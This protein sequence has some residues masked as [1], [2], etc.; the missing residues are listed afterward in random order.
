MSMKALPSRERPR[1]RLTRYGTEVLSSIELLAILLGSGTPDRT[2][3]Q[4]AASPLET[5]GSLQAL[6]RASLS[7][8]QQV[9]GIGQA[10]AVQIQ[11]AFALSRRL[12][13]TAHESLVDEPE[14][15]YQLIQ[16]QL[17]R[18][19]VELLVVVLRD[20][21]R[22]C[23]HQEVIGKGTLTE[24]L[25]H[26]R[27]IFHTAIRHRAHSVIIA[28]NHPSGKAAPSAKDL[29]MTRLLAQAGAV[30]GIE[31]SDHL[32]IGKEGYVSFYKQ[33]LLRKGALHY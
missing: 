23:L 4:L 24:L 29:E 28:H 13:E 21:Q 7:E 16:P 17:T 6:S 33:G 11:A 10:K 5:F 32:I 8:L 2:V 18:S 27:E 31:L 26:P 9:K 22:K 15:V 19:E 25:I 14:K 3:L 12:E 1:E 20:V 30:V